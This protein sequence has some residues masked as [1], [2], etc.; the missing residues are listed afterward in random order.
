MAHYAIID[1]CVSDFRFADSNTEIEFVFTSGLKFDFL[2]SVDIIELLDNGGIKIYSGNE[3]KNI[4]IP[5]EF[6]KL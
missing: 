4:Q 1:N 3:D 5:D 2:F 6:L